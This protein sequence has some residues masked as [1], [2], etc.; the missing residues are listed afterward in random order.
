MQ[1]AS[2]RLHPKQI[3]PVSIGQSKIYHSRIPLLDRQFLVQARQMTANF[4]QAYHSGSNVV[5]LSSD[6][7]VIQI[8]DISEVE[9]VKQDVTCLAWDGSSGR[10]R[11]GDEARRC[12]VNKEVVVMTS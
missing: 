1:K 8:L 12:F 5:I 3:I 9:G 7:I 6:L 4:L 10:V 11:I 2:G